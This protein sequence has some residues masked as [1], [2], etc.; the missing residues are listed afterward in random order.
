MVRDLAD[1]AGISLGF[2]SNSD[3]GSGGGGGWDST[4]EKV[5]KEA[6]ER[7]SLVL[8]MAAQ[9]YTR[10]L[11]EMPAAGGARYAAILIGVTLCDSTHV[12]R[13]DM[14]R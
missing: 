5:R 3:Y 10:C 14:I 1:E 13:C 11:V 4:D 6:R 7:L 12:M 2:D 8:Q 9:F